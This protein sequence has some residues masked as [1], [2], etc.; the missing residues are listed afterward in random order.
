MDN[1]V[2]GGTPPEDRNVSDLA[3]VYIKIRDRRADLKKQFEAGDKDLEDQQNL[4]A[5]KMLDICKD[6]DADSIRTSHGTIIRSVKSRYWT[7]DWDSMY[8]F[9]E[10][11]GAFGLLEKRLHQTNMK[12]FL[13]ENPDVYPQGLNVES[14]YTVVVRR[15]KEK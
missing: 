14:Q 8:S 9:I 15:S 10:E 3:A 5:E 2:Q 13:S 11:Q 6:M 12:D 4:L 1:E 7:N